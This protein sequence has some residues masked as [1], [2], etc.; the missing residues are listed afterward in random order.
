MACRGLEIE[1]IRLRHDDRR[2]ARFAGQVEEARNS[3]GLRVPS[4]HRAAILT[5]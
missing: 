5:K 2:H 1:S 3:A 4:A